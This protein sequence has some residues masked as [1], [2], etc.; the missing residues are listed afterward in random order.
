MSQSDDGNALSQ[1]QFPP[2]ADTGN[3]IKVH[4]AIDEE[5]PLA[6]SL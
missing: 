5:V 3:K 1:L 6:S 2:F 4:P